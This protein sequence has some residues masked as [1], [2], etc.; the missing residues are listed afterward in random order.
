M[1]DKELFNRYVE[2]VCSQCTNRC[3]SFSLCN[4]TIQEYG[5]EREAKC[6]YYSRKGKTI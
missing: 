5:A 2:E 6:N 4:I 1:S 3:K